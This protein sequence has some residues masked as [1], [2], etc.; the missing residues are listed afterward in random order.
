M[1][2]HLSINIYPLF[3]ATIRWCGDDSRCILTFGSV[4]CKHNLIRCF[5]IIDCFVKHAIK[6]IGN[7]SECNKLCFHKYVTVDSWHHYAFL[8]AIILEFANN[9]TYLTCI[10]LAFFSMWNYAKS[11][12]GIVC[13]VGFF[14]MSHIVCQLDTLWKCLYFTSILCLYCFLK[15]RQINVFSNSYFILF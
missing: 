10:I 5:L 12:I 2:T 11:S 1:C 7:S 9:V 14:Y 15:F 8:Y 3:I 13:L 6:R 4:Y